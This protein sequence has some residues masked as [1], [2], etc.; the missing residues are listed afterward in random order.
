MTSTEGLVEAK[1]ADRNR[2][3]FAL[4]ELLFERPGAEELAH[5]IYDLSNHLEYGG[6]GSM[7]E[8]MAQCQQRG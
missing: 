5:K 3:R 1:L 2:L 4:E 8:R 6:V 7:K